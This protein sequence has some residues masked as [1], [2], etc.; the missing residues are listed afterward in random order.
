M[1]EIIIK[2]LK[3]ELKESDQRVEENY[4]KIEKQPDIL[5][6]FENWIKERRY[7]EENNGAVVVNGYSAKK[8]SEIAKFLEPI[9]VY[10]FLVDLRERPEEAL[11]DIKKGFPR[12]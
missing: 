9:G 7:P 3:E 8:L 11:E 10:N 1:K 4:S 5:N 2:Y 12:K 6:E